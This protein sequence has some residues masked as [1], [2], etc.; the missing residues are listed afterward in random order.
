MLD[1]LRQGLVSLRSSM[2]GISGRSECF[3][4]DEALRQQKCRRRAAVERHGGLTT[5]S[6]SAGMFAR[7]TW[8]SMRPN[9]S[10]VVEPI[11]GCQALTSPHSPR[12]A[13]MVRNGIRQIRMSDSILTQLPTPLDCISRTE[14]SPPIHLRRRKGR[15]AFLFGGQRYG[16]H[17]LVLDE[18]WRSSAHARRQGQRPLGARCR[19]SRPEYF[20]RPM[21]ACVLYSDPVAHGRISAR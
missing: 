13:T 21:L 14:R 1:G 20:A 8:I 7:R 9:T 2:L 5:P 18:L 12:I 19:A 15:D 16:A 6:T 17:R 4:A 10:G 3:A 11:G